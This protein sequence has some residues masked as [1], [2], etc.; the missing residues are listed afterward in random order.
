MI[1]VLVLVMSPLALAATGT[2]QASTQGVQLTKTTEY[3]NYVHNFVGLLGNCTYIEKPMF[4]VQIT[5]NQIPIG[6][7]WTI[8]CPLEAGH[9]YHV[10]F[11][12]AYINTSC[13]AK[14]DYNVFVYDPQMKL[15]SS[16]TQSAGLPEHLGTNVTKPLFTPTESGNW[17]FVI[18]NDPADSQSS[19]EATFMIIETLNTNQW[20]TTQIE[21]PNGG[22]ATFYSNWAYEFETNAS[23]VALYVKVPNTLD[24]YEAR[25][26]LMNNAE[27]PALDNYPL[28][29]EAGLY[30]NISSSVGGYNF[31]PNSYRGVAYASCE[32]MGQTMFLNY[33]SPNKGANLYHLVLMGQ[34]GSGNITFMLKTNFGNQTLTPLTLPS[35]VVPGNVTQIAYSAV[36]DTLTSAEL[37]YTVDNWNSTSNVSMQVNNETCMGTIP[38]QKLGAFVQYRVNATDVL[39]N[40][41]EASGS[42]TVKEPAVI[43]ITLTK[44][45]V[46]VGQDVVVTGTITPYS[47]SSVVDVRFASAD[48][49][50]IMNCTAKEGTFTAKW[51]PTAAGNWTISAIS[52]ENQLAFAGNSQNVALTVVPAPLYVRYSLY[53]IIG[54]V[55]LIAVGGVSYVISSRRG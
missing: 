44:S 32:Y 14:T 37:S 31:E 54:F 7:N 22:N 25:L 29:W 13:V 40:N 11:Y 8:I 49:V 26:Y 10:Y 1:I 35:E 46:R 20:Y 2:D 24:M 17:T 45:K 33:T 5:N 38:G 36:N 39:E 6:G 53:I 42:Y 28:P 4:P 51:K 19:Q 50:K 3:N 27:S 21:S 23:K 47:N 9:N 43:N 16:H 55:A 30:G 15:E 34:I 52:T 12:G 18:N 41:L 48:A